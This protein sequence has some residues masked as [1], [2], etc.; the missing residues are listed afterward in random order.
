M[1][2]SHDIAKK[3]G[4]T[5]VTLITSRDNKVAQNLYKKLGYKLH[6]TDGVKDFFYIEL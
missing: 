3:N 6:Q 2:K 5:F 4:Y 1:K